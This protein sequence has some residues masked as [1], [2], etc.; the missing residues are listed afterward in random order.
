M[1]SGLLTA[2]VAFVGLAAG[3]GIGRLKPDSN[4]RASKLNP[5]ASDADSVRV[6][7]AAI[8]AIQ[9]PRS[10]QLVVRCFTRVPDGYVVDLLPERIRVDS[11]IT[12]GG[13]GTV[14]VKTNGEA[15]VLLLYR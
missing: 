10:G 9:S 12:F 4:G 2:T 14:G 6:V 1:R 11:M 5:N 13:G 8:S 15:K 3:F 7:Q